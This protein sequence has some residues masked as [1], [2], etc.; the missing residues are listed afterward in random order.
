VGTAEEG[1]VFEVGERI[2]WMWRC[3]WLGSGWS[4]WIGRVEG[5]EG[6]RKEDAA[7]GRGSCSSVVLGGRAGDAGRVGEVI[8]QGYVE[9]RIVC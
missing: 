4:M 1:G 6:E 2:V 8:L 9:E 7:R 3:G 5:G